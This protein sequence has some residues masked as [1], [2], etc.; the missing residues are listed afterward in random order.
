MK[1][2]LFFML[3]AT[4]VAAA[5]FPVTEVNRT[6]QRID[7]SLATEI[8]ALVLDALTTAKFPGGALG[9]VLN[10]EV[11]YIAG[12]G[13]RDVP[14]SCSTIADGNTQFRTAS[15]CKPLTGVLVNLVAADYP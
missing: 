9:V 3:L 7:E 5:Q 13:Y 10:G 8:D 15:I 6:F 4:Q 1:R 11:A 12:F 2:L 14:F